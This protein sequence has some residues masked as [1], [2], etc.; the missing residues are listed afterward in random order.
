MEQQAKR[1]DHICQKYLPESPYHLSESASRRYPVALTFWYEGP[2]SRLQYMTFIS[3]ADRGLLLTRASFDIGLDPSTSSQ[4]NSLN[5][6]PQRESKKAV[7]KMSFKD[8]QRMKTSSMSPA[9]VERAPKTEIGVAKLKLNQQRG[10]T[11]QS[12]HEVARNGVATHPANEQA[13]SA[14]SENSKE[15]E[16]V[17]GPVK[18]SRSH[19]EVLS[20]RSPSS[21]LRKRTG[22]FEEDARQIKR[23]KGLDT[24]GT[25]IAKSVGVLRQS[26]PHRTGRLREESGEA[27]SSSRAAEAKRLR[28]PQET[29]AS[30]KPDKKDGGM[31][32]S[33][34]PEIRVNGSPVQVETRN[35]KPS[36]PPLLSPLRLA[37]S[38]G[39]QDEEA[40]GNEAKFQKPTVESAT[41]TGR[42]RQARK[43]T[44]GAPPDKKPLSRIP[45]LLSPTLPAI[46]EAELA[47]R[48]TPLK[49][50]ALPELSLSATPIGNG[51]K[52]TSHSRSHEPDDGLV[53]ASRIVILKYRKKNA[54]RVKMLLDLPPR[55]RE[56]VRRYALAGRSVS[57]DVTPPPTAAKRPPQSVTAATL[58]ASGGFA[59]RDA[60]PTSRPRPSRPS[61]PPRHSAT[62]MSRLASNS[63][64]AHTPG[65]VTRHT[66]E[67]SDVRPATSGLAPGLEHGDTAS[68]ASLQQ[69][70]DEYT[71]MGTKIKHLRDGIL[72]ANSTTTTLKPADESKVA[73]LS[74]EMILAYMTAFSSLTRARLMDRKIPRYDSW[75]SLL[76]HFVETKRW[77]K[78]YPA[79]HRL[80]LQLEA[81][82][83]EELGQCYI[84]IDPEQTGARLFKSLRRRRESWMETQD[85]DRFG[86]L[87]RDLKDDTMGPWTSV[88]DAVHAAL[89]ILRRWAG[90]ADVE[91]RAH[92]SASA[93]KGD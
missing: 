38:H 87:A 81:I 56:R 36:V 62:A 28:P 26:S 27:S 53:K 41:E 13:E 30:S 48:R 57:T 10:D 25:G 82:S 54:V 45:P 52:L 59:R 6:T 14:P 46:V 88:G 71:K 40:E 24:N 12:S 18:S 44:G 72:R 5:G 29:H 23:S 7:N 91:W 39:S 85:R 3:D 8:Y 22:D 58:S 42:H 31:S 49:D 93:L 84:A 64:Q 17:I 92:L 86:S 65:E 4:P 77:V 67:V 35:A 1:I 78:R 33:P 55:G 70:N 47:L 90:Q 68:S 60:A 63:S 83:L 75:E 61:T 69:R 20:T 76:P 37:L 50:D 51:L 2:S 19:T 66:P 11:T 43:P 32:V 15:L 80:V 21:Q 34:R 9:V 73:A 79:L 74:V 16:S 89:L